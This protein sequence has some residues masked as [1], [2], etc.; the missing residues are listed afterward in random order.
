MMHILVARIVLKDQGLV[1]GQ[2]V[3]LDP[4]DVIQ[5]RA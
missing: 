3:A 4:R 5:E 2:Q 1:V